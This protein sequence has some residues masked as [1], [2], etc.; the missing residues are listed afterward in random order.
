MSLTTPTVKEIS[1]NIVNQLQVSL[2]QTVPLL[3]R[4]FIRVL[5]KVLA[6]VFILLFKYGGFT[7]QQMFVTTA[8][9]QVTTVNG[10]DLVPLT[11]LGRLIGV[12]DPIGATQAELLIDITVSNQ[13]GFLPAGSQLLGTTNGVTYITVGT[14]DLNA[15]TVQA[16]IRAIEDGN[17]GQGRGEIGNLDAGAIVSF[18]NP[19]PNVSRECAVVSQSVTGAEGETTDAYRAR[20]LDRWQARPQGGAYADYRAWG[21]GVAGIAQVYPYTGDPAGE[22]DVYV[23][24]ATEVDGIPTPAQLTAVADAIELDDNGLA[25]RR[26]AGALVNTLS[27]TRTAWITT[28]SGLIPP[29]GGSI[30]ELQTQV[31]TAVEAYFLAREPFIVGLDVLPRN[32]IITASGV[33]GVVED[34]VTAQGGTFTSATIA[35]AASPGVPVSIDTLGEGEKAKSTVN[36]S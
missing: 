24:S 16:T 32:D 11:E 5:A 26:P 25:T 22:V 30:V 14:V 7:L 12:G 4:A 2:G 21:G 13:T 36:F 28:V 19:L 33:V 8:S 18:A 29:S 20:V 17:G 6:G 23:E 10:R 15:P 27:I 1:D 3:P 34:V 9:D 31:T 35:K